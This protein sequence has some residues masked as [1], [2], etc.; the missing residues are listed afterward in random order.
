[1]GFRSK[2]T[3]GENKSETLEHDFSV[4]SHQTALLSSSKGSLTGKVRPGA[5]DGFAAT[6]RAIVFW[7]EGERSPVP[8][9][10]VGGILK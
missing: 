1:M 5:C 8:L 10:A 4:C 6:S 7:V 3:S 2:V 9:Q